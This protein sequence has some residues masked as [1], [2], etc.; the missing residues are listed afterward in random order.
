MDASNIISS[1][2]LIRQKGGAE[3]RCRTRCRTRVQ[4]KGAEQGCR[5]RVQRLVQKLGTFNS[6]VATRLVLNVALE[7]NLIAG[8]N[9][10]PQK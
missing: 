4:N 2:L 9:K 3:T 6:L 10:S 5:N 1:E 8:Y 7:V